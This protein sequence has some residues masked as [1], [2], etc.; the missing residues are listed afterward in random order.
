MKC[1]FFKKYISDYLNEALSEAEK[2]AVEQHMSRC[3]ICAKEK[4]DLDR[5]VNTIYA[6]DIPD[7]GQSYWGSFSQRVFSQIDE[8]LQRKQR[9]P[10]FP[11][12]R[13]AAATAAMAFIVIAV[14]LSYFF[15]ISPSPSLGEI[16]QQVVEKIQ[17]ITPEEAEGIIEEMELLYTDQI[18]THQ[19]YYL[20][21]FHGVA[22][23]GKTEYDFE[24]L[25][26][27]SIIPYTLLEEL[28]ESEVTLLLDQ[29]RS[30]MG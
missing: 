4:K 15:L 3:D 30:E 10:Y 21:D 23:N 14:A 22:A 20:Q 17:E 5:L 11:L 19:D 6:Q 2:K 13:W 24:D 26:E 9:L 28:D 25:T 12:P 18:D 8:Q 16:E 29:I 27:E 1:T 7:P